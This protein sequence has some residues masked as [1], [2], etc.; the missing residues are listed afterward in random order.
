[1]KRL[2]GLEAWWFPLLVTQSCRRW[3]GLLAVLAIVL[4][5]AALQ[6]SLGDAMPASTGKLSTGVAHRQPLIVWKA[7]L[8]QVS[9][10]RQWLLHRHVGAQYSGVQ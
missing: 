9:G 3:L 2:A 7:V 6:Q 10:F 8:R 4:I 1:M 5:V